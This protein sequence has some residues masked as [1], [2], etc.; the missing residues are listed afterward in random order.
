MSTTIR[1]DQWDPQLGIR[2]RVH[3]TETKLVIEKVYDA[4]PMVEAAKEMRAIRA[5]DRWDEMGTHVGFIP[6]ADLAT[7]MRQ[8]GG[9]DVKRVREFLQRNPNFVTFE[10]YL[11]THRKD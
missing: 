11:K 8:D 7:M 10:K 3:E 1:L 5:G 9:F 2:T 4:E 6:M